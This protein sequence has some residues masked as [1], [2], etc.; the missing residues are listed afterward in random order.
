MVNISSEYKSPKN[1]ALDFVREN[2]DLIKIIDDV[3]R[4]AS[5]ELNKNLKMAHPQD[6]GESRRGWMS[7]T[8]LAPM[9]WLVRNNVGYT[10]YITYGIKKN[11]KYEGAP[12]GITI[13]PGKY[14]GEGKSEGS[15][16]P[17]VIDEI[18]NKVCDKLDKKLEVYLE[19]LFKE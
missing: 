17:N 13:S 3:T 10:R 8:K 15:R 11:S 18:F 4:E 5:L 12:E 14:F 7:P 16:T 2:E 9:V 6:T 1:N 19:A